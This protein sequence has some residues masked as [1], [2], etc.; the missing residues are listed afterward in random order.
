MKDLSC[1]FFFKLMLQSNIRFRV[2]F[3]TD[4]E[5]M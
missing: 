5:D 1:L 4:S 3:K 2:E